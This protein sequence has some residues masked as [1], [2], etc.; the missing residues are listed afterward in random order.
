MQLCCATA[1]L[2]AVAPFDDVVEV[3]EVTLWSS[4][5]KCEVE[6]TI[7]APPHA[8]RVVGDGP[9][10]HRAIDDAND[11]VRHYDAYF[12]CRRCTRVWKNLLGLGFTS[13]CALYLCLMSDIH[14]WP[15][16][17]LLWRMLVPDHEDPT[18]IYEYV[19][20]Y[21]LFM[22]HHI[23]HVHVRDNK[24]QRVRVGERLFWLSLNC[25]AY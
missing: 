22:R 12:I 24:L 3:V 11:K 2:K 6:I 13:G 4:G 23:V 16:P 7:S 8:V 18:T 10:M 20:T 5:T 21:R 19:R 1:V 17:Y 15:L 25:R 14:E 9:T